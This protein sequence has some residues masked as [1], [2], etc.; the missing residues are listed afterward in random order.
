MYD[1]STPVTG[2]QRG[3]YYML[4]CRANEQAV[5]VEQNKN[6]EHYKSRLVGTKI[7]PQDTNTVFMVERVDEYGT[8]Y[9]I[10]CCASDYVFEAD[11][12]EIVLND[13]KQSKH[14]LF[15]LFK[16]P[17]TNTSQYYFLKLASRPDQALSL[18]GCLRLSTFD[19]NNATQ[20]F[21]LEEVN[22]ITIQNSCL[23]VSNYSG[24]VIDVPG[25]TEKQGERIVVWERNRRWNQRWYFQKVG[26]V[27]LIKNILSG[28]CLD[29][30]G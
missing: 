24:K 28:H 6:T 16:A 23:I 30:A 29:I 10:V 5:R 1:Y 9:E 14:Q 18:E 3:T 17:A 13:G 12:Q 25:A 11:G 2:F 8:N 7:N 19:P 4:V 15:N 20:Q 27:F 22:N 26:S 21:R